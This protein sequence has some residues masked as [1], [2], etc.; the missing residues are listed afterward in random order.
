MSESNA[1]IESEAGAI[2]EKVRRY[3]QDTT[4]DYLKYYQ[5]GWHHH[6][7]YG[8]DRDLPKGG[9]PT[10]Q[11]VRYLS[12]IASLGAGDV[13]LDAGCGVGGSAIWLAETAGCRTVGITLV[14]DQARL[15][16]GF[17][18]KRNLRGRARFLVNDFTR[19][20]FAPASFDAVWALESF[21]HAPDKGAWVADM[22]RLL[23][24]G[25]RL[26]IADGFRSV[27]AFDARQTLAYG[28]FLA[29]WAVPHLCT[30]AE[31]R[32]WGA[33]AGFEPV[34]AEDITADVYP[35]ARAIFRF[36]VIF[37]PIRWCLRRLG[38][39]S[40]EKLGNALATWYQYR[41]L[42]QGLWSYRVYCFRKPG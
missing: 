27:G 37:I 26:V 14:E 3:Y 33:E 8:F 41:T 35:H 1:V 4:A 31:I 34:H 9:N 25:G 18:A 6:M 15:A 16:R 29:G 20:A 13:V 42:K 21:D 23:R 28:R 30:D 22:F 36:G 39:V 32:G 24:P 11:M 19:T 2:K 10:E 40:E 38:L 5:T 17:A 12:G 7:H